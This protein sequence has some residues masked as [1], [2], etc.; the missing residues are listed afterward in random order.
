MPPLC[1]MLVVDDD[2]CMRVY[3]TSILKSAGFEVDVADSGEAALWRLRS[4]SYDMMLT[5]Y[6][7]PEMDGPALC[8]RVRAEFPDSSL[9]V[10]MFTVKDTRE[11]RYAG[12]SSGADE[13]IIK[14]STKSEVLAKVNVGRRIQLGQ[15]ALALCDPQ[16]LQFSLVDPLTNA[17]SLKYFAR[18]MPKEIQRARR[19]Q[20]ALSVASCRIE[21]FNQ[22][23]RQYGYPVA[24]EAVRAFA[25]DTRQYLR[26]HQ[27][28]FARVGED[29]FI[30]VLPGIPF[31][32]AE[33]L[34]R[35]LRRRYTEVPVITKADSIRCTLKID[36]TACEPR[37]DSARLAS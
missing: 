3:L 13:Y 8:Q 10:L 4:G 23:A 2:E 11:D 31:N 26:A 24:D 19:R 33:R 36:V 30:L 6:K 9:Y 35:K 5:D 28:W 22:L 20:Q 17:H 27:D 21:G 34:A 15:Q 16:E 1:R 25:D 7:M 14:G 37:D 32:A 18:Q 29:R 12:L